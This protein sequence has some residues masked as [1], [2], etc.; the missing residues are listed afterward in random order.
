MAPAIQQSIDPAG[1]PQQQT[2]AAGNG[3]YKWTDTVPLHRPSTAH[4]VGSA[5]NFPSYTEMW[6]DS[7]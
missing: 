6:P 5:N 2:A 4:N 7:I 1:P 3:T